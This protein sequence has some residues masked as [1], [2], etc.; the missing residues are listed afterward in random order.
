MS[1]NRNKTKPLSASN[2]NQLFTKPAKRGHSAEKASSSR[3]HFQ[4]SNPELD[5]VSDRHSV[6]SDNSIE[7]AALNSNPTVTAETSNSENTVIAEVYNKKTN[8]KNFLM[9][10]K[11]YLSK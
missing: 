9:P 10:E 5:T 4:P 1:T 6:P 7:A 11:L 3:D 2:L 8:L